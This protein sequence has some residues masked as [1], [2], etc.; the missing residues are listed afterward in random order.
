MLCLISQLIANLNYKS[1]H[2]KYFCNNKRP[3]TVSQKNTYTVYAWLQ[4]FCW[5]KKLHE[6]TFISG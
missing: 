1:F 2:S 5:K 4:I 6:L 3:G